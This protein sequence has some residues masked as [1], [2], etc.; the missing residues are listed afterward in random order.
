MDAPVAHHESRP[1][2]IKDIFQYQQQLN[3]DILLPYPAIVWLPKAI[4]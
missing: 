1:C 3:I 4:S 2:A